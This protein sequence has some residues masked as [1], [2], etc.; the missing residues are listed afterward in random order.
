[1]GWFNRATLAVLFL[2]LI[3]LCG[4]QDLVPHDTRSLLIPRDTLN[5][6]CF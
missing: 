4:C 1:M 3:A 5:K 2:S 6:H